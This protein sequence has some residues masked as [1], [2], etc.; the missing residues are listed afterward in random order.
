MAAIGPIGPRSSND[1][2]GTMDEE[3]IP[4][5]TSVAVPGE[6]RPGLEEPIV[7]SAE[8]TP[9]ALKIRDALLS[10]PGLGGADL[11]VRIRGELVT[12]SGTARTEDQKD[13]ALNIA[14]RFVGRDRVTDE[15]RTD[16]QI[17]YFCET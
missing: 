1:G 2:L 13:L 17:S 5:I 6:D 4:I 7:V 16:E 11:E 3:R 8:E 10:E 14:G 9:I 15:I 12:L